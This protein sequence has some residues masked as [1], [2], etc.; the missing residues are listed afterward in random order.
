MSLQ[1][2]WGD[3]ALELAFFLISQREQLQHWKK[4]VDVATD[5]KKNLGKKRKL[6][7]MNWYGR[8][9]AE[10]EALKKHCVFL[11]YRYVPKSKDIERSEQRNRSRRFADSPQVQV[12]IAVRGTCR[13]VKVM[14]L[15]ALSVRL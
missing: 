10:V 13:C 5:H 1:L 3:V 7:M 9:A 8:E 6:Y 14:A 15:R 2:T 12:L 4:L 11:Y